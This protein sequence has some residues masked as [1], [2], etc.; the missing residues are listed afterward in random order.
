MRPLSWPLT[1]VTAVATAVL[2][3]AAPARASVH[4]EDWSRDFDQ[5]LEELTR[6][7]PAPFHAVSRE[8]LVAALAALR[9]RLKSLDD[10]TI[11]VELAGIVARVGDGHT[12]LTLP[13]DPSHG[14]F[15]GHSKTDPPRFPDVAMAVFPVRFSTARDGLLVTAAEDAR[16]LGARVLHLGDRTAEEAMASV[17]PLAHGD[18]PG[19][20]RNVALQYLAVGAVLRTSGMVR[21]S[22][23][24]PL[25]L[26]L[27]DGSR[28]TPTLAATLV[29]GRP[30]LT[31]STSSAIRPLGEAG[32]LWLASLPG[33]N[34]LYARIDEVGDDEEESFSTFVSRLL[35]RFAEGSEQTLVLDLRANPGGDGSRILPLL[36]GLI[37]SDKASRPGGLVVLIGPETF[38]AAVMLALDLEHHL[39]AFFVGAATGGAP[40]GWGESRKVVLGASGLTVRVS[41]LYWQSSDPR[42]RR[43]AILPDVSIEP[44]IAELRAGRD[45]ALEAAMDVA[46]PVVETDPSAT[47]ESWSGTLRSDFQR[48]P[49]TLQLKRESAGWSAALVSPQLGAKGEL[50]VARWQGGELEL[51]APS[52]LGELAIR[53]SHRRGG[54][55][56]SA[57]ASGSRSSL[58]APAPRRRPRPP[59]RP[60][61][62]PLPLC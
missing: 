23:A 48:V 27:A 37:R 45:V 44:T 4:A 51:T 39:P 5:L 46:T 38:S 25:E 34:A 26:E 56:G 54:L 49:L 30:L 29:P 24:L 21:D 40:N 52:A 10:A 16:W 12:R 58:Y 13:V 8:E 35:A 50:R 15:Q 57:V 14:F 41:T 42:D 31:L 20:A 11:T 19:Q 62:R 60:L 18:N 17:L 43:S 33:G 2:T 36:H 7:H 28:V 1:F 47:S 22:S 59:L 55:V 53:L 61:D 32:S 3:L 9:G 6:L